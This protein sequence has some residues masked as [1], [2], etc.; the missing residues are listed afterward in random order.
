MDRN[1]KRSSEEGEYSFSDDE[2]DDHLLV[3]CLEEHENVSG[4]NDDDDEV[5]TRP[6]YVVQHF[7]E[8]YVD[9]IVNSNE[10]CLVL[11]MAGTGKST[12]LNKVLVKL[13]KQGKIPVIASSTGCS[14]VNLREG[15]SQATE[16]CEQLGLHPK[17]LKALIPRTIHSLL[18]YNKADC[19]TAENTKMNLEERTDQFVADK[20]ELIRKCKQ[21]IKS[22]GYVLQMERDSPEGLS[23]RN[24]QRKDELI[25]ACPLFFFYGDVFLLDELSM[26]KPDE[27]LRMDALSVAIF[28]KKVRKIAFGDMCQFKPVYGK[29]RNPADPLRVIN[30]AGIDEEFPMRINLETVLRTRESVLIDLFQEMTIMNEGMKRS[31]MEYIFDRCVVG[32]DAYDNPRCISDVPRVMFYRNAVKRYNT[33]YRRMKKN[34]AEVSGESPFLM[35]FR[36]SFIPNRA[37]AQ[38]ACSADVFH[39]I[40][41]EQAHGIDVET[42]LYKD[43]LVIVK[44][45]VDVTKGVA[46][47]R[48]GVFRRLSESTGNAVVDFGYSEG[49]IEVGRWKDVVYLDE[50]SDRL[51][52]KFERNEWSPGPRDPPVIAI[53]KEYFPLELAGAITVHASQ[54]LT[55]LSIAIDLPRYSDYVDHAAP[56]VALSRVRDTKMNDTVKLDAI[57]KMRRGDV[58]CKIGDRTAGLF[59][60]ESNYS[61]CDKRLVADD[62][63]Q[64]IRRHAEISRK[65][66]TD[67]RMCKKNALS[68]AYRLNNNKRTK[69]V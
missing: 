39:S 33:R 27:W 67:R 40:T 3:K 44:R 65:Q 10:N 50:Y 14:A 35:P 56:F 7:D 21:F 12:C 52:D 34:D 32:P 26:V 5:L 45:N 61:F 42:T 66:Q 38:R 43:S 37:T 54:G 62:V 69:I 1:V 16:L 30:I 11:G 47:G 4:R 28:G 22:M 8:L 55:M 2:E 41:T 57:R 23:E 49:E 24:R 36:V 25:A 48:M 13:L 18:G 19:N 60:K 53:V 63:L 51:H 6:E 17:V 15:V 58:V 59:F 68:I 20:K 46:N 64:F 31:R 29:K 9:P